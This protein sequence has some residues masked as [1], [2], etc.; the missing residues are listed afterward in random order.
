MKKLKIKKRVLALLMAFAL[1]V[2]MAPI[3]PSGSN[4]VLAEES[5]SD[6]KLKQNIIDEAIELGVPNAFIRHFF[7]NDLEEGKIEQPQ[8]AWEVGEETS[9]VVFK[10]V[11]STTG[12]EGLELTKIDTGI[13]AR[14]KIDLGE[15][16]FGE[17]K[18]A[19]LV[20]NMLAAKNLK[21]KGYLYFGNSEEPFATIS[22]KRCATTDWEETP[23]RT[24][25]VRKAGLSGKGHIYL[26]FVADSALDGEN[27]IPKSD[28]KGTIY[29]ESM[30]FT[31]GS[32]P[33]IDFDLDKEV[34]TIENIN[35]SEKHTI[36]GYGDMNIKIPD[37]Y[38]SPYTSKKLKDE[39]V[40][41]DYIRGRGN[42]TWQAPKKPYKLKLEK[43]T[44]L[45]GMGKSKHWVLLA[46]YYD[47]SMLRNRLTFHLAEEM[48]LE[49]TPKSVC[50]DMVI[51]GEYYGS[52]QLC[53]HVRIG[54]N[55]INIDDLE[56]DPESEEP[57]VTG[58]YLLSMGSSWL[59]EETEINEYVK[60]DDGEFKIE[61]PE[62][63]E[64]YP[65]D[66]KE[67]QLNY[68]NKYFAELGA[69]VKSTNPNI[70]VNP[71]L[72]PEGKTWRDYMDEQSYIDYFLIQEFSQNGDAYGSGST[73][74]YKPRNDKLYW[75]PVWDFD[76][77]AWWA[78]TNGNE[79]EGCEEGF[80]MP[81]RVP[82]FETLILND[83]SFKQKIIER[84]N[85]YRD[86]LTAAAADGGKLD[87][88]KDEIYYS[89][90]ANYQVRGTCLMDFVYDDYDN[91]EVETG[92]EGGDGGEGGDENTYVLNYTNEIERLKTAIRARVAWMD[93]NIE[94]IDKIDSDTEY[95]AVPFYIDDEVIAE[96]AWDSAAERLIDIPE[97]PEKKGYVAKGWYYID[98]DG[99][100][101]RLTSS[102]NP[103]TFE[104]ISDEEWQMIPRVIY[105]KY[106]LEQEYKPITSMN[107]ITDVIYVP[108][109]S[110]FY[111]EDEEYFDSETVDLSKFISIKPFDADI[112][113][114]EWSVD[115]IED[116]DGNVFFMDDST[117]VI[118]NIG[119]YTAVAKCN[120]LEERVTIR[121][122]R[123]F[124]V[125]ET[126][127]FN[128]KDSIKL[129]EGEYGSVDFAFDVTDESSGQPYKA[130]SKVQFA[131]MDDSII[132]IDN[133]GNIYAKK[134]GQ[135][136]AI[137]IYVSSDGIKMKYTNV[138]VEGEPATVV[139]QE[140]TVKAPGKV[141]IKKVYSKKKSSNKLKIK[142][143]K[144]KS[145]KGYQ[146]AVFK[147]YKK[148][149]KKKGALLKKYVAYKKV[150]TIKSKK[151]KNNKKL[152]V[153]VRAYKKNGKSKKF[154]KWSKIKKVKIK[155]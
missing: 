54:K 107:F 61:T 151:L 80:T 150:L 88:Y 131:V 64:G 35:G 15:Y 7:A 114:I 115:N 109:V 134:A 65:E 1:V 147:T 79:M 3:L 71:E 100:E 60:T 138:T 110:E 11:K 27:I 63:E 78:T 129:K 74:L 59:T 49:F 75:G 152:Y 29:F 117:L 112:D 70:E 97:I 34:N 146:V 90:L 68:L 106:I 92:S 123:E 133:H 127:N 144:I 53:Q 30:F 28:V 43:S 135:T 145:A 24:V 66:A 96:V 154:G 31:E 120:G 98:D 140:T 101:T 36:M 143:K 139:P 13:L 18:T 19:Y 108:L 102:S 121:A 83:P 12:I 77:V 72:V 85:V 91:S 41:L 47:Y 62:Y 84:W 118:S 40:E 55:N 23:N 26:K 73:Y 38:V 126:E 14:T 155:K 111:D 67:A 37:G 9:E 103:Y 2:E 153:R 132:D 46:N 58:G 5:K 33:V 113:D 20:Y 125:F 25:D 148:A 93:E 39:T 81:D 95:P 44:D 76:Y 4:E 17:L 86:V 16:D 82:W 142:I 22:V 94:N 6:P 57:G 141:V 69:L 21:G 45:F 104:E 52:Y 124:D 8:T 137:T 32:T 51:S 42:S 89:V 130:Y 136:K 128:V 149:K 119:D 87:Q 50:V 122:V 48:G 10:K 99:K 56:E 116:L 105:A